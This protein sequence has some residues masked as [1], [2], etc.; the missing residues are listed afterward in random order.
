M[1]EMVARQELEHD[2]R[3]YQPGEVFEVEPAQGAALNYQHKASFA[4][5]VV[6]KKKTVGKKPRQYRRRDLRAEE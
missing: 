1:V 2:G 3:T 5:D 4:Q 6:S